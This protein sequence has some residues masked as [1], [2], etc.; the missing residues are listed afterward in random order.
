[1][2][3]EA[4]GGYERALLAELEK[5]GIAFSLMQASRSGSLPGRGDI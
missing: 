2:I 3:C 4:S 5:H 1:M